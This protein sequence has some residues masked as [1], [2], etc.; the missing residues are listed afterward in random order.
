MVA[1][2]GGGGHGRASSTRLNGVAAA[3]RTNLVL[4]VGKR[5]DEHLVPGADL[6]LSARPN[7]RRVRRLTRADLIELVRVNRGNTPRNHFGLRFHHTRPSFLCNRVMALSLRPRQALATVA[8]SCFFA[9]Q[10]A[11][12][13]SLHRR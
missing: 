1:H 7:D 10:Y 4:D 8:S 6:C 3:T 12:S 9:W 5:S 11:V 2:I 13:A